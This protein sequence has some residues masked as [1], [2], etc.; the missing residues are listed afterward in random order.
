MS[1]DEQH[2]ASRRANGHR[3]AAE[4]LLAAEDYP[5][6]L[7]LLMHLLLAIE[8]RLNYGGQSILDGTIS[9]R[10]CRAIVLDENANGHAAWHERAR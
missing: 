3:A 10:V 8:D 2:R 1:L 9:C 6:D 4:A 5:T 7:S